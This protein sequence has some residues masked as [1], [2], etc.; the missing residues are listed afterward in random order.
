MAQQ[1][2]EIIHNADASLHYLPHAQALVNTE[3]AVRPNEPVEKTF[4]NRPFVYWDT[5]ND[6][7]STISKAVKDNSIIPSTLAW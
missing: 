3:P 4:G 7:P 5:N 1:R 2:K 6:Y